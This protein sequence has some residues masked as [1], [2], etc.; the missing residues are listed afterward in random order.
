M[1]EL[2]LVKNGAEP[3]AYVVMPRPM[4]INSMVAMPSGA[5]GPAGAAA[6]GGG[7]TIR[8]T[9]SIA[10]RI[11]GAELVIYPDAGHG[12]IFQYHG[13]FVPKALAFLSD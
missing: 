9:M 12:G 4:T 10:R 11:S 1:E 8:L 7:G 5:T 3:V 13:D 6:A 2:G